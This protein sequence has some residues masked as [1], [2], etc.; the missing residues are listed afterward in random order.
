MFKISAVPALRDNYIWVIHND[1]YAAVVDPGEA[2]PALAFLARHSLTLRHILC[3]HRHR[4]HIGGI[5]ALQEVYNV[6]VHGRKHP[7]NPHVTHPLNEGMQLNLEEFGLCF[8]IME[9]PGHLDDHIVYYAPGSLF[10]GDMMFG[11]GCGKNFEG[12]LAQLYHSLQRLARLPENTQ[13]YSAHE[14]TAYNLPFARLCEPG[15]IAIKQRQRD[16]DDL[17]AQGKP[18]VPFSLA[19]EKA[20]NPFIRCDSPEL[21]KTLQ[22]QNC[23]AQDELAVFSSLCALRATF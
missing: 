17:L 5:A 6:P 16:T 11:A 14:Y 20:T 12:T 15:N 22:S 18:S 2:A 1:Q 19:L 3:T 7:D 9:T 13:I 23:P 8:D 10:C 4:D 21:T